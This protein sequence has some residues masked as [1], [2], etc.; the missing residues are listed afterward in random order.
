MTTVYVHR[1]YRIFA[2]I[3]SRNARQADSKGRGTGCK[4]YT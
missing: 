1:A 3:V 2:K 4:R